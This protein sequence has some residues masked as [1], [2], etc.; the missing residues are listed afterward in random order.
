MTGQRFDHDREL[1]KALRETEEMLLGKHGGRHQKRHLFA[2]DR[3]FERGPHCDLGFPVSDIAAEQ[4]VHRA[5]GF[6]VGLDLLRR[7]LLAIGFVVGERILEEF[8]IVSVP[9]ERNPR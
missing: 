8:L 2:G 1:R 5:G 4:A 9:R 7:L 3:A 6:H